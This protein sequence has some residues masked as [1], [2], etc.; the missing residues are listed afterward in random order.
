VLNT[1]TP[2]GTGVKVIGLSVT[3]RVGECHMKQWEVAVAFDRCRK[4][5]KGTSDRLL[6]PELRLPGTT[7]D[8]HFLEDVH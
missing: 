7:I 3:C 5:L 8:M 2:F 6:P 4:C 1:S